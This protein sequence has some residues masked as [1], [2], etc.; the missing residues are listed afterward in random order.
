MPSSSAVLIPRRTQRVSFSLKGP[1]TMY[2]NWVAVLC[3]MHYSR[4]K[5]REPACD[6]IRG[7]YGPAHG[8]LQGS[9]GGSPRTLENRERPTGTGKE[10]IEGG[11]YQGGEKLVH[12]SR[13]G[14]SVKEKDRPRSEVEKGSGPSKMFGC[15]I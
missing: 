8:L 4:A 7:T 9:V 14:G 15:A 12:S 11:G 6:M 2:Y 1:N 10:E 3:D 13:R 5:G